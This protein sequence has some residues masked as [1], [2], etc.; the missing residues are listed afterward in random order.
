MN[1][2]IEDELAGTQALRDQLLDMI[3]DQDLAY[4]LPGN[5]PTLGELCEDMGRIQQIYT[6]SFKTFIQD[7]RYLG[8]KPEAPTT[9]ASLRAWYKT[10]DAEM[11]EAINALTEEELHTK[12]IDRGGFTPTAFVHGQVYHEALLI[13]YAK[14]SV[15][16][17]ALE[18]SLTDQWRSWIG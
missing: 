4:K 11:A 8:S 17:Q 14:A 3:T 13:F 10:L 5:N 7:W 15:Y 2:L 9:V 1:S 18:K 6:R 12:Q 16:L